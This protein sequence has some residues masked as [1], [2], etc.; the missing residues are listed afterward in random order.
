MAL[1][2]LIPTTAS[3]FSSAVVGATL[4]GLAGWLA[5]RNLGFPIDRGWVFWVPITLWLLTMGVLCWWFT[6]FGDEAT[7]R[8]SISASWRAGRI[9][10]GIGLALGAVGPLV[11]HPKGNLGPLLGILITGPFGFVAGV[12]GMVVVRTFKGEKVLGHTRGYD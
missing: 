6:L 10:G 1:A 4:I 9:A 5:I 8:A 7:S 12:I 3:R 11:L 2:P